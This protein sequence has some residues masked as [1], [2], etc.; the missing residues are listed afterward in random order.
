MADALRRRL[1]TE[2]VHETFWTCRVRG[3]GRRWDARLQQEPQEPQ[4]ELQHPGAA[5]GHAAEP[6]RR[7]AHELVHAALRFESRRP[8]GGCLRRPPSSFRTRWTRPR[9]ALAY[10]LR[11]RRRTEEVMKNLGRVAFAVVAAVALSP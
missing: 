1:C 7:D 9:G 10:V 11:V 4:R 6:V 5:D 2:V 3:P 8:D